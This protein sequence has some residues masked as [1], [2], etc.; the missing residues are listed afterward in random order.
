MKVL[1]FIVLLGLTV[2]AGNIGA[3]WSVN[4]KLN[5]LMLL[6]DNAC[7]QNNKLSF[8]WD[9]WLLRH[10]VTVLVLKSNN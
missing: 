2:R 7:A 4:S 5:C 6:T 10:I 8:T 1:L 3:V 9:H